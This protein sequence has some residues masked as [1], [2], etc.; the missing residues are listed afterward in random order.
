VDSEQKYLEGGTCTIEW[1]VT[2]VRYWDTSS[3]SWGPWGE[4]NRTVN[5]T[6]CPP[7]YY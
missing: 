5:A 6:D 3:G 1:T 7:W 2:Y 4:V